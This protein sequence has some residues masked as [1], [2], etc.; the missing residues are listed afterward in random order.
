MHRISWKT[1]RAS[2]TEGMDS[3]G[4]TL[5]ER[6]S[7]QLATGM[8]WDESELVTLGMIEAAAD[9]LAV[10]RDKFDA[11]VINPDVSPS[12]LASLSG[13]C[14]L[15]E[16]TIVRWVESLDPHNDTA[17]SMRHVHAANSRWHR[18]SGA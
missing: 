8:V 18:N 10:M 7:K 1:D 4:K 9:R 13:E 5:V 6:L 2:H 12:G 16:G 3:P 14:R 11:A 15:V 17:K